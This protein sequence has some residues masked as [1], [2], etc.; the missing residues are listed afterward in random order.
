VTKDLEAM[1]IGLK[2]VVFT[3]PVLDL[4][5]RGVT[6]FKDITAFEAYQMV[7]VLVAINMFIMRM[8]FP[9]TDLSY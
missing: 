4:F 1:R 2:I 6:E 7:M 5:Y 3:D 8:I 9:K